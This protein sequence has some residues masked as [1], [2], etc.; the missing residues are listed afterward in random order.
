MSLDLIATLL[1]IASGHLNHANLRK[2]GQVTSLV[3]Q[4][5]HVYCFFLS[6][7]QIPHFP[8]SLG[9]LCM[10]G[11]PGIREPSFELSADLAFARSQKRSVEALSKL[12]SKV[13]PLE[14]GNIHKEQFKTLWQFLWF[15]CIKAKIYRCIFSYLYDFL[16]DIIS[17]QS[18]W[19]VVLIPALC[20][21]M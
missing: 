19:R 5:G 10:R 17:L 4:I 3:G 21:Q 12:V 18:L 13:Q 1:Y 20:R 11:V 14:T 6:R 2:L 16:Y 9:R 7:F 8:G 15:F